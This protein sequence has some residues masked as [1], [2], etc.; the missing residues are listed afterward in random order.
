MKPHYKV[1][2]R[3]CQGNG[4][5]TKQMVRIGYLPFATEHKYRLHRALPKIAISRA[6]NHLNQRALIAH[7]QAVPGAVAA[8]NVRHTGDV[9]ADD[10]MWRLMA[11]PHR[12]TRAGML[13]R[14]LQ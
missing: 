3:Q 9:I 10:A 7:R 8:G 5:K 12:H 14:I 11:A 6:G 2:S 13:L 4:P 1:R